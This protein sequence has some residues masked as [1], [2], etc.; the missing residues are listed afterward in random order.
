LLQEANQLMMDEYLRRVSGA[1]KTSP[2]ISALSPDLD[3]LLLEQATVHVL[4][5]R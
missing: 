3:R 5:H 2:A 1:L 4:M